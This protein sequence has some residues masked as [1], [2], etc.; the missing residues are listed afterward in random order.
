MNDDAE[1]RNLDL[2][3]NIVQVIPLKR[4]LWAS[5]L[6]L[7]WRIA[8]CLTLSGVELVDFIRLVAVEGYVEG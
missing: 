4:G 7:C 8:T 1:M 6:V 2:L 5:I 3:E